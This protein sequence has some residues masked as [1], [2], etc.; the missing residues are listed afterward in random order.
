MVESKV[1]AVAM[2]LVESVKLSFRRDDNGDF[3]SLS[4][5]STMISFVDRFFSDLLLLCFFTLFFLDFF[6]ITGT[7]AEVQSKQPVK[8][9]RDAFIIVLSVGKFRLT[10]GTCLCNRKVF[11]D[12]CTAAQQMR[13]NEMVLRE[14]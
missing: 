9:R 4:L 7:T 5:Y 11:D 14:D 6:G 1:V 13:K 10:T 3:V 2:E 8:N 12:D